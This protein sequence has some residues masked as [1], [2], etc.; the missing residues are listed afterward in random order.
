MDNEDSIFQSLASTIDQD[1]IVTE[2]KKIFYFFH[3]PLPFFP[4]Q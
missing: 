3:S 4:V 2:K 1:L